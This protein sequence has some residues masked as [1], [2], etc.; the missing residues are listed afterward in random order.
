MYNID[1]RNA[2]INTAE[3][4]GT[5]ISGGTII[6]NFLLMGQS[7]FSAT[8]NYYDLQGNIRVLRLYWKS[9]RKIKKVN[10]MILRL[11]K[12]S[13]IFIQKPIL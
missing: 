11:A 10:L 8:S 3:I 12:S 2:F 4:D 13:L 6:E 1:E 9:K 5:D 7:G